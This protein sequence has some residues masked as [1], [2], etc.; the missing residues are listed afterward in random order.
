MAVAL[1]AE[2]EVEAPAPPPH[3]AA[4]QLTGCWCMRKGQ[5]GPAFG[6]SGKEGVH[7]LLMHLQKTKHGVKTMQTR[8]RLV[9]C[10]FKALIF[11][12]DQTE[13]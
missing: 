9:C 12:E 5:P 4:Y 8:L 10:C 7:L 6:V 11:S 3:V 13:P 1:G 2:A